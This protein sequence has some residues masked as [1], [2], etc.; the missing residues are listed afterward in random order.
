MR[1]ALELAA[2]GLYS[3]DPNPRV[4]CVLVRAGQIVGEGWHERAGEPHAEV[5]ALRAA[6]AAAQGATAYVTLEPC[7]HVGRTPPCAAALISA[8]VARVVYAI[9][10]P[11]P[12]VDGAGAAALSHA[13]IE[14]ASGLLGEEAR[15]LN[16]GFFKRLQTGLPWVRVKLGASLD[17]RTAL[18]NGASRWITSSEA[19]EDVQRYR[20]RSSAI[21]SASGT[22]LADDPALTVRLAL[23]SRQPLRVVLDS[24]LRVPESARVYGGA[25]QALVFA[26]D[27]ALPRRTA[28][29]RL[30]VRVECAAR[31]A[32]GGLELEPILRRLAQLELNEIWVEAGARLA[33]ALLQGRWVDELILYLSPSLLGPQ[34]RPLVALP[35]IDRLEQRL[36]GQYTD[37]TRIGEDLRLTFR[38][39]MAGTGTSFAAKS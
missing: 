19:R 20:A 5:H 10:D 31:A 37:C 36:S 22:V 33:G 24:E 18:A 12:L 32:D 39:T 27:L 6:G 25:G 17:G 28:L 15:A 29:E 34:A 4:G 23:A 7:A 14:V 8:G 16:P 11:N 1:R 13:G 38:P 30:G 3:T 35:A 21:L 26:A 2:R 9:A